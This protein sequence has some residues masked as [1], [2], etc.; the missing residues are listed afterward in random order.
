MSERPAER[1]M[2]VEETDP[3]AFQTMFVGLVGTILVV[4]AVVVLQG[5][6][7]RQQRLEY[8]KKVVRQTPRELQQARVEQ[9]EKFEPR[10]IDRDRG[11]VAIPIE[12][13]M[14]LLAGS[15]NPAAPVGVK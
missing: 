7:D 5:L 9:L 4:V 13:A 8:E 3:D 6:Y 11:I 12:R 1:P 14:E 10:W 2:H 15:A